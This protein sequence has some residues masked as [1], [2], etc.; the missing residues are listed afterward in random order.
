MIN[1]ETSVLKSERAIQERP[2]YHM[3]AF[4]D[5]SQRLSMCLSIDDRLDSLF[6]LFQVFN[7]NR[8][9]HL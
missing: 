8:T 3:E 1:V 5:I 7:G 6:Y 4:G 2:T 9:N